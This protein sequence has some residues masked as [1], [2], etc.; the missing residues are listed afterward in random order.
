MNTLKI[1]NKP[2]KFMYNEFNKGNN[3]S[4]YGEHIQVL[5]EH[6]ERSSHDNRIGD[7]HAKI[8]AVRY[9]LKYGLIDA[10]DTLGNKITNPMTA[11]TI[12]RMQPTQKGQ[13]YFQQRLIGTADAVASVSGTFFGKLLKSLLGK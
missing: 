3:E 6:F 8:G 13:E 10:V 11:Y 5:I 12:G 9:F 7:A 2:L 1:Y 4:G